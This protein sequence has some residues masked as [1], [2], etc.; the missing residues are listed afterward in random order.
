MSALIPWIRFAG[1]I[2]LAVLL[3]N[4]VLPKKLALRE[5]AARLS[6][7]LRQVLYVHWLYILIVLLLFAYLCFFFPGELA[8][9]SSLGTSLSAFLCFF[10]G[11]RIVLQVAAYDRAFRRANRLL[12]SLYLLALGYFTVLFGMA[13]WGGLR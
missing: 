5:N 4:F 11:L 12:D 8:G 9:A 2:H 13:A 1:A 3:A 7:M 10:W 6:P